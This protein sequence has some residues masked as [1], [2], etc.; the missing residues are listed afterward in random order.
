MSEWHLNLQHLLKNTNENPKILTTN[1]LART[2]PVSVKGNSVLPLLKSK[3]LAS[4]LTPPVS[5][6][7]QS[8]LSANPLRSVPPS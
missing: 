6:T 3:A 8:N 4:S 7:F 5:L 1:N 2:F